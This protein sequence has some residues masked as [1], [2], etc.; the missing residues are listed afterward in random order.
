MQAEPQADCA[1]LYLGAG[2]EHEFTNDDGDSYHLRID[3]IRKV[4]VGDG[5]SG[6]QGRRAQ[7]EQAARAAVGGRPARAA[8][9][10]PAS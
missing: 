1:F 8:S 4:K 9:C 7:E 2:S 6:C 10:L 5:S 3:E